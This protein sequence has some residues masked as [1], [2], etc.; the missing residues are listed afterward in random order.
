M[1]NYPAGS[2]IPI[3]DVGE[4]T[5][6]SGGALV[7]RTD[8]TDCCDNVPH[9]RSRQGNWIYPNGNPV[10]NTLSGDD[11]YRTRGASTVLLN[12]R[13]DATGPTGLYCCEVASVDDDNARICINLSKITKVCIVSLLSLVLC[14]PYTYRVKQKLR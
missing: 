7:C 12:R 14:I 9:T 1:R 3:T 4:S 8:R 10:D 6:T 5:P 13:N 11:I 2:E